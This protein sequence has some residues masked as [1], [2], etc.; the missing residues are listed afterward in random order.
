MNF[1]KSRSIFEKFSSMSSYTIP[2]VSP[3]QILYQCDFPFRCEIVY[4]QIHRQTVFL[5]L[6]L[7]EITVLSL[8]SR[9]KIKNEKQVIW[10]QVITFPPNI[11]TL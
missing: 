6:L 1:K 9:G 10:N 7:S 4:R 3:Y 2:G 8:V 11:L 5:L